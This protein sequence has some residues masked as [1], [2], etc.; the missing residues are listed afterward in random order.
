[1]NKTKED[2]EKLQEL[3]DRNDANAGRHL[4]EVI[5]PG[6][7]LEAGGRSTRPHG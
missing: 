7:R 5:T 3:L 2:L 1:V 6:R 4:R